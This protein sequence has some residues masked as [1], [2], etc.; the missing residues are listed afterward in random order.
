MDFEPRIS[1][2]RS[3]CFNHYTKESTVL[4]ESFKLHFLHASVVCPIH[5]IHPIRW[6]CLHFEKTGMCKQALSLPL[7]HGRSRAGSWQLS[8]M[9]AWRPSRWLDYC[10]SLSPPSARWF[11]TYTKQNRKVY[12]HSFS[13][14]SVY[15]R[16]AEGTDSEGNCNY[17]NL[18]KWPLL[19]ERH[20][21][22]VL[23]NSS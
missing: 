13:V 19:Y 18:H 17:I 10:T 20:H 9:Q 5:L 15:S 14:W 7:W 12:V 22:T 3:K 1:W 6:K 8:G 11:S 4:L 16:L 2:L 21:H 23:I